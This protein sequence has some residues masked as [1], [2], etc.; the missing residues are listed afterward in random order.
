VLVA[1]DD[2]AAARFGPLPLPRATLAAGLARLA[3]AQPAVLAVDLLIAEP[4]PPEGD[5]ALAAALARFPKVVLGTALSSDGDAG[6]SWIEP[7]PALARL[8]V[9]AHVHAA[10]D[11]DGDVRSVL[12]W[13]E[14]QGK[15]RWAFGLEAA[16]LLLNAGAP[17]EQ[18]DAVG[19][20]TIRIPAPEA[21]QRALWV[22]YAGPEGTFGRVSFAALLERELDPERFR[23]RL[24]ILGATAQGSGDRLFTPLSSGIGMSGIEIHANL[25]RT[26][27]DAAF[28]RPA[29]PLAELVMALL[30]IGLAALAVARMSGVR[31]LVGGA[32]LA[33]LIFSA[34]FAA[35]PLG[36][37]L[38]AGGLLAVLVISMAIAS[39]GEF[40][41]LRRSLE[42]EI[43]RRKEYAFRVQAMAHEIKTPLTAI[44]GSSELIS[45]DWMPEDQR[46]EMAG[47]IHKESKR[48]ARLVETF[49]SVERLAAGAMELEKR[50]LDLAAL[51]RDVVERG[52]LY[53][54][55]KRI[56]IEAEVP[57]IQVA[58][59]ADLLSFA[60]YNLITNG[61]KYSPRDT[62][63]VVSVEAAAGEVLI[64]VAD[65]GFGVAPADRE[66][67]FERFYRARRDETGAEAG[68]G[69][70]LALVKE[71]VEQ[72]G[73]RIGVESRAGAGS[74][75][76]L[77]L[78]KD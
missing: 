13:K 67:I 5:A 65:E 68:S 49:L 7:L 2:A 60:L 22:N 11:P 32:L 40:A 61:V 57:A 30:I 42:G 10:P 31:L 39:A 33:G 20:G 56:A 58:A 6:G 38:P 23:G 59:D 14:G 72:H 73:G 24:V 45:A 21:A 26:I 41:F 15:R 74:R 70:G 77:T 19:L 18:R 55:R 3:G 71:I 17:L 69:I 53:A 78:P 54:A 76:T 50:P 37:L 25:A 1:I 36:F 48:L 28:L 16:R 75:F 4:G 8:G 27:L 44:Q 47:L 63:I 12:L 35:V 9:A 29:S 43:G 62:T 51:C 46:L 52:R 34:G 66:R 64:S